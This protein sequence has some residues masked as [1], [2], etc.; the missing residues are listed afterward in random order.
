MRDEEIART[1]LSAAETGHL[2]LPT[3]HMPQSSTVNLAPQF[4]PSASGDTTEP[5]TIPTSNIPTYLVPTHT[6]SFL[7]QASTSGSNPIEFDSSSPAGDP[8]QLHRALTN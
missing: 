6:T 5:L 8:V 7:E 1:A 2:V 3:V 4:G